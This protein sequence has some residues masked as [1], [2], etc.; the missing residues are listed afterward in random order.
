MIDDGVSGLQLLDQQSSSWI[1]APPI[2]GS[3][4]INLGDAFEHNTG[5]LIRATPH[6]VVQ[7]SN[8]IRNRISVPY[9]YDPSFDAPLTSIVD[10]LPPSKW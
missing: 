3:F 1:R 7:S 2:P 10:L 5:G 9:F 6:R 4:V 8:Q